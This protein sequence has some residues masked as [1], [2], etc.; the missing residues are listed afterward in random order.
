MD[1]TYSF[2]IQRFST[3][4]GL[5]P[6]GKTLTLLWPPSFDKKN[7]SKFAARQ[8]SN[9]SVQQSNRSPTCCGPIW[10]WP[11]LGYC[12][13]RC[14][15]NPASPAQSTLV[16]TSAAVAVL[17]KILQDEKSCSPTSHFL[18]I[19]WLSKGP[20]HGTP[21]KAPW[22]PKGATVKQRCTSLCWSPGPEPAETA[23]QYNAAAADAD[24]AAVH[25]LRDL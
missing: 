12:Q 5:W 3:W 11:S 25:S 20:V 9:Y 6:P 15:W 4:F 13:Y 10:L 8:I 18:M 14:A 22:S 24:R 17:V 19:N 23:H 16:F 1:Y 7:K 2:M 21:M